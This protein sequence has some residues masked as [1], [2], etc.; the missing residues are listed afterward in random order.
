MPDD[1]EFNRAFPFRLGI[2][3]VF[4]IFWVGYGFVVPENP[5]LPNIYFLT[6]VI[7]FFELPSLFSFEAWPNILFPW[8]VF[9]MGVVLSVVLPSRVILKVFRR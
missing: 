4:F 5:H 1:D 6:P 7:G 2:G 9:W 3:L 8:L